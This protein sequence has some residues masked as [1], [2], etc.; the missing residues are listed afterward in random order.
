MP[1]W[2]LRWITLLLYSFSRS[3]WLINI[4]IL[5]H[6]KLWNEMN[7]SKNERTERR[8]W[9]NRSIDLSSFWIIHK[10]KCLTE[11][12]KVCVGEGLKL[13]KKSRSRTRSIT[14]IISRIYYCCVILILNELSR[15]KMREVTHLYLDTEELHLSASVYVVLQWFQV[16]LSLN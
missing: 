7:C 12:P 13:W 14:G 8:H 1:W 15:K 6:G 16:I 2:N 5:E 11:I 10:L 3:I 4:E 9:A